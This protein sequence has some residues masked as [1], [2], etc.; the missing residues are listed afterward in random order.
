[1][2]TGPN[3]MVDVRVTGDNQNVELAPN[4]RPYRAV[5]GKKAVRSPAPTF[6]CDSQLHQR[7]T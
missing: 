4:W 1:M 2:S 6:L 5:V 7:L 3:G